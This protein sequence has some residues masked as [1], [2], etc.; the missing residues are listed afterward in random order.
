M[1]RIAEC[2]YETAR[3]RLSRFVRPFIMRRL[4][5]DV[6]KELPDKIEEVIYAKMDEEQDKLYQ[7][8]EK[9]LLMTCRNRPKRNLRHKNYGYW[10]N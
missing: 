10:Q 7:A 1:G 4:K 2:K 6:L 9:Q 5:K 3:I 8:R